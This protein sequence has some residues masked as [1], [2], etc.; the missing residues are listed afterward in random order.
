MLQSC[1]F[2]TEILE[3]II[4]VLET[5]FESILQNFN[6]FSQNL[7][8]IKMIWWKETLLRGK[9][10]FLDTYHI[11][12][13]L[14]SMCWTIHYDGVWR[15]SRLAYLVCIL[16]FNFKAVRRNS[17]YEKKKISGHW[18]SWRILPL[19]FNFWSISFNSFIYSG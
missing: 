19:R 16:V 15:L 17:K 4:F 7:L 10:A 6:V 1:I 14:I 12:F 13:S 8:K 2:I 9:K 11:N 5:S 3:N 18:N